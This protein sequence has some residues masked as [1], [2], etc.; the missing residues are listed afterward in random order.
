MPNNLAQKKGEQNIVRRTSSHCSN[1]TRI[2]YANE[3]VW[4][5]KKAT[6][7]WG[8]HESGLIRSFQTSPRLTSLQ[9]MADPFNIT[10]MANLWIE[11][12]ES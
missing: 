8:C 7:I 2:I 4:N 12:G 10:F 3:K 9:C 1:E 6:Q 11:S 5:G